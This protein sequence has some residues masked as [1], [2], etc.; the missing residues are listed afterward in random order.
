MYF[1]D[2]FYDQ[3]ENYIKSMNARENRLARRI[4]ARHIENFLKNPY[5]FHVIKKKESGSVYLIEPQGGS[6]FAINDQGL[7]C[8]V[9]D[10]GCVYYLIKSLKNGKELPHRSYDQYSPK[11]LCNLH[12][13]LFFN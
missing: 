12:P 9:S 7:I 5:N 3:V 10:P 13:N 1:T 8:T 6:Y 4:R 11:E 2:M